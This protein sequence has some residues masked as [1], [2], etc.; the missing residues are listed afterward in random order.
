MTT[1][2]TDSARAELDQCVDAVETG[3]EF[4]LAYAAQGR[5][6]DRG[7]GPD[8]DVRG[9]LQAMSTA[10]TGLADAARRCAA[11]RNPDLLAETSAFFDAIETDAATANAAIRLV[12]AQ[13]DI[14]SQ[15]IDNL[16]GSIHLRAVLTD[17]FVVDEALKTRAAV[18]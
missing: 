6:T 17:I 18:D 16:N 11:E 9:Y 1:T 10:L 5:Q 12:L 13:S 2:P 15:L 8:K 14:G 3:Y 4:L 7:A